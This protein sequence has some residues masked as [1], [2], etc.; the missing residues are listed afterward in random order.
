LKGKE[1]AYTI[2]KESSTDLEICQNGGHV[3]ITYDFTPIQSTSFFLSFALPSLK[4][5]KHFNTRKRRSPTFNLS[6]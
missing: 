1:Y 3:K 5:L 4:Q 6:A 2:K